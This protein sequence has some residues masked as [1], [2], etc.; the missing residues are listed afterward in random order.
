MTSIDADIKHITDTT[1]RSTVLEPIDRYNS[2]FPDIHEAIK[3]RGNKLLDYDSLRDK[4][5][6]LTQKPSDDASRLPRAEQQMTF[7]K[8]TYETGNQQLKDEIPKLIEAR[9]SYFDPSFEALVKTQ[10]DYYARC[11]EALLPLQKYFAA[12]NG[13]TMIFSISF[14]GND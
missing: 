3:R 1:F 4:V 2:I 10:L 6:G 7:A 13:V 8:E 14:L 12:E 11:Y 5:K 9:I